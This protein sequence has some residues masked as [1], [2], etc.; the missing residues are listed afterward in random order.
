MYENFA[1]EY[2]EFGLMNASFN[3]TKKD[4]LL[5]KKQRSQPA[6]IGQSF[7]LTVLPN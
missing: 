4:F 2:V 3:V 6:D 1:S 5:F 7:Q